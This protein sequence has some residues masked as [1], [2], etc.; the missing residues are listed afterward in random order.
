MAKHTFN[1]AD[2]TGDTKV[3]ARSS[4]GYDWNFL[5]DDET[6]LFGTTDETAFSVKNITPGTGISTGSGTL[7]KGSILRMGDV[8][9]TTIVIDLTG[10]NSGDANLDIIGVAGT[11]NSHLGQIT[12]AGNGTLFAG[13]MQCVET[14]AGGEPDIDLYS[15]TESTGTEEALVTGLT[16]TALLATAVDWTNILAPKGLTAL[17]AANEY[18]YLAASGGSTNAT[19]TAGKFVIKLYGY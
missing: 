7:F 8:I 5:A 14:P 1:M 15:A 12:A 17:P 16:E 4:M 10:L 13:S 2:V 18:L 11:A 9:E 19:Y 6:L 3:I